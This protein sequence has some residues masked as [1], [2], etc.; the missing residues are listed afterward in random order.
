MGV[1]ADFVQRSD[2]HLL[3]QE[4]R[5]PVG[6]RAQRVDVVGDHHDA[7]RQGALQV[8]D[9]L[10]EL[11]RPDRIEAGGGLVEE[12]H[13]GIEGDGA[14]EARALAHAAGQL[15]RD[16]GPRLLRQADHREL[17][18]DELGDQP[19]VEVGV[20]GEGQADVLRHGARTEQRAVLEQHAHA[21][22][23]RAARV[24]AEGGEILAQHLD[25]AAVGLLE[26]QDGAQQDR[27]A[28]PRA[29]DDGD[30]LAAPHLEIDAVVDRLAA[31]ARDQVAHADDGFAH[32]PIREKKM[33]KPA[34][35]TITRKIDFTTER[36]VWMPTL[37]AEPETL[38]PS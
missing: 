30:D 38:R 17:D 33:E 15:G 18:A 36:V 29:A 1:G 19:V 11:R 12:Q 35:K 31:E 28:G 34:S 26:P 23:D 2:D 5:D 3:V 13:V 37:S 27:L 16:L 25:R 7:E 6:D 21:L 9:Q 24:V 8:A 4:Y 22:E 32:R 20:L 14:R 10:V